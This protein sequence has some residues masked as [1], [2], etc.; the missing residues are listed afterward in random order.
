MT[1]KAR[2]YSGGKTVISTNGAE[3]LQVKKKKNKKLK[4]EPS[5]TPYTKIK[6]KWIA[7]LNVRSD[8]IKLLEENRQ[9]T[10]T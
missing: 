9:K 4:L 6:S 10:L 3:Q 2:L 8:S 7:Y 1:K 5:L